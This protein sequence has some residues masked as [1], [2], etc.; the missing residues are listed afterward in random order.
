MAKKRRAW[1]K[2]N[3]LRFSPRKKILLAESDRGSYYN[4][5]EWLENYHGS[6]PND[7][8]HSYRYNDD[9]NSSGDESHFKH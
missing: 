5:D 9:N 6:H 7:P 4:Q 3:V 8:L 1:N 2:K